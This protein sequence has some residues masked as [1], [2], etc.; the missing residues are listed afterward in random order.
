M[1]RIFDRIPQFD[2]RSRKF[3]IMA[4]VSATQR[5][6][7]TWSC[8]AYLD[9]G[10]EGACVGFGWTHEAAARPAVVQNLTNAIAR[11]V[12]KLAQK[13]DEWPGD[14]YE[15]SSV[16]GGAKAAQK[17]GWLTEYRWAFGEDDLAMAVGYKGPAVLGV[18][19]YE[20]MTEPDK[21]GIIR[22]TG[23]ALGGHCILCNGINVKRGLYRLHN[24]WGASWGVNGECFISFSD[25]AT[26]LKKQGEACIPVIRGK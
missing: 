12:Y 11:T 4:L 19:W 5:R 3:P 1:N 20:G 8:A 18:N 6:S 17:M 2:R 23:D 10:S 16:L 7:Y 26:L 24:S 9:Q 22:P 25:M 21:N 15:G 14:N 13:Y